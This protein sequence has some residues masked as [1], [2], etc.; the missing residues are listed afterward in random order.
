M[1]RGVIFWVDKYELWQKH[2]SIYLRDYLLH[3]LY[4]NRATT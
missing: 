4:Q 1:L 3:W 2:T